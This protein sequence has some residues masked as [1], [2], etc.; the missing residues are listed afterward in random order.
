MAKKSRAGKSYKEQYS[1]YKVTDRWRTN[2]LKTLEKH[3]KNNPND[4]VAHNALSMAPSREYSRNR[5]SMGHVCKAYSYVLIPGKIPE[6]R[7]TIYQ[8]FVDLGLVTPR[9]PRAR[10]NKRSFR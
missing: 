4:I 10:K 2:M 6:K 7:K 8:Q 9:K 3:V 1:A 5:R